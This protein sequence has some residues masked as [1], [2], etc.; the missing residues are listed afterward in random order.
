MHHRLLFSMNIDWNDY[1]DRSL[2]EE[3]A[4]HVLKLGVACKT[5]CHNSVSVS[6]WQQCEEHCQFVIVAGGCSLEAVWQGIPHNCCN[7]A[8]P[9][10]SMVVTCCPQSI[11]YSVSQK[12]HP[13][14]LVVIFAKW[15]GIFQPNFTCLLCFPIYARLQIFIQL[16]ATLTKLWH[17]TQFTSCAKCPPSAK[18][19]TGIFWHFPQTVRNF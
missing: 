8:G 6:P 10:G 12:S 19:H 18:M 16:P 17:I 9:Y 14:G 1:I 7:F 4:L 15:L 13:W 5:C 2:W 11:M 3:Y